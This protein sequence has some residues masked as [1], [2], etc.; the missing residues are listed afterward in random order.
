MAPG[1]AGSKKDQYC[2]LI[3]NLQKVAYETHTVEL[4][5]LRGALRFLMTSRDMYL[6]W[7][8]VRASR[9]AVTG[10]DSADG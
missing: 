4:P 10:G 1:I 9:V 2:N 6:F 3:L 8:K 5:E 7:K